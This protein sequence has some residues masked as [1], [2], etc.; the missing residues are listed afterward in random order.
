MMLFGKEVNLRQEYCALNGA[1]PAPVLTPYVNLYVRIED[2]CQATCKFCAY[3]NIGSKF[4]FYKFYYIVEKLNKQLSIRKISFTGGEPTM[5]ASLRHSVKAVKEINK[6]IFTVVNTNGFKMEEHFD[7]PVDSWAL[8]RHHFIDSN[9]QFILDTD[10]VPVREE[11]EKYKSSIKKKIHL[12]YNL[13]KGSIDSHAQVMHYLEHAARMGIFDVGFVS[14]M[15]ATDFA[16]DNFVPF[17]P[18]LESLRKLDR[19]CVNQNWTMGDKCECANFLYLPMNSKKGVV[20]CYSRH[21]IKPDCSKS[22]GAQFF[23]DGSFLRNGFGGD[24]II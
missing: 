2:A 24:I 18:I 4:D 1:K 7:L 22:D 8:S 21:S 12:S 23:Y 13:I 20:R 19:V 5:S 17:K 14:L 6:D 10:Q 3:K 16:K 11:L 15:P 9:N